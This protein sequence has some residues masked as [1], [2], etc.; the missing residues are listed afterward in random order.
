MKKS[1]KNHVFKLLFHFH[2]KKY[3]F[4]FP[5]FEFVPV[6]KAPCIKLLK[7]EFWVKIQIFN[8]NV[9]TNKKHCVKVKEGAEKAKE[10]LEKAKREFED[11]MHED[12]NSKG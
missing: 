6:G 5:L 2:L 4:N 1:N 9:L 7:L 10:E 11:R 12:M 3:L 8:L